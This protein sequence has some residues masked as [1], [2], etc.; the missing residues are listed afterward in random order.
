MKTLP[1]TP[2]VIRPRAPAQ[3]LALAG[4]CLA[5]LTASLDTSITHTALPAIAEAFSASF[6]QAQAIVIVYLVTL[7]ALAPMA[8]RVGDAAGRRRTLLAGLSVFILASALCAA[9]PT[10]AMLLAARALQGAGAAVMTALA[11]A[12]VGDVAAAAARGRAMG[13]VGT[14]SAVGTTLGP[15][16]GGL[17]LATFGWQCVFVVNIPLG[18]AALMLVWRSLPSDAVRL[19]APGAAVASPALWRERAIAGSLA[20]TALVAMVMMTTLVVGPFYL[21]RTLGLGVGPVGLALSAGPLVAALGGIPAGV[22]VDRFGTRR[23]TMAGLAGMAS[24]CVLL[25]VLPAGL[26]TYLAPVCILTASYALF[27]ASNGSALIGAAGTARRGAAAGLLGMARNLGLIGGASL[28]GAVFAAGW[29][30]AGVAA[31]GADMVASGMRT[32]FALGAALMAAALALSR[33]VP[34]GP[35][36]AKA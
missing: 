11:V 30:H 23:A 35:H 32:T 33:M 3:K 14:M 12:L 19:P 26:A 5:M 24:A 15:A 1:A 4:I 8:G 7:T 22:L 2:V 21:A 28:M 31:A 36:A 18:L 34:S 13:L 20:M 27:Q 16:L 29:A 25:A 6:R 9:A 17:L 10:L